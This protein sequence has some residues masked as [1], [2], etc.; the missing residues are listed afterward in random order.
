MTEGSKLMTKIDEM[1]EF[2]YLFMGCYDYDC[3]FSKYCHENQIMDEDINCEL[4][5]NKCNNTMKCIG[6]DENFPFY[7]SCDIDT[8]N[9][10]IFKLLSYCVHYKPSIPAGIIHGMF[11]TNLKHA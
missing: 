2:Y 9:D 10:I 11:C 8:K 5:K 6:Y 1:M 4:I 3:K 7:G